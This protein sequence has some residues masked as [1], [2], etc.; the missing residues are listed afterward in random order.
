MRHDEL[1]VVHDMNHLMTLVNHTYTITRVNRQHI[2]ELEQ[3]V[4][5]LEHHVMTWMTAFGRD[6]DR[7]LNVLTACL[8]IDDAISGLIS[9]H[10]RW[11]RQLATYDRQRDSVESDD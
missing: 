4:S 1:H 11:L 2:R 8:N 7:R 5:K 6:F 3:Y 9:L 10:D